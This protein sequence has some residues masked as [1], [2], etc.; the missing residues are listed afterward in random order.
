M[1]LLADFKRDCVEKK[2]QKFTDFVTNISSLL[3]YILII[4]YFIISYF[5]SLFIV[6]LVIET[7]YN[8]NQEDYLLK[9]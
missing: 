1:Y 7:I 6:N 9:F 2:L 3:N 8:T 4:L 5:N